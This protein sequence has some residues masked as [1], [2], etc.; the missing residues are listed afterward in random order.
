VQRQRGDALLVGV[1][2]H[3]GE[4]AQG[5]AGGRRIAVRAQQQGQRQYADKA[6]LGV[7]HADDVDT[8]ELMAGEL[9]EHRGYALLGADA[10]HAGD[11]VVARGLAVGRACSP[12]VSMGPASRPG[13]MRM[14]RGFA[15][16]GFV[17]VRL[18]VPMAAA[19]C[20]VF[21]GCRP[22]LQ[23]NAISPAR[24]PRKGLE[25]ASSPP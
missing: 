24:R 18:R 23:G 7:E 1:G 5:D 13:A 6:L 25:I 15:V 20:I 10:R 4:A 14:A 16:S 12:G 3:L 21:N 2:M 17:H 22:G 8:I 9:G 11:K 19:T